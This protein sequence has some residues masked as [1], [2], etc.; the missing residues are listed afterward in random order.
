[1]L[2]K[3]VKSQLQSGRHKAIGEKSKKEKNL[4]STSS[5]ENI[6]LEKQGEIVNNHGG[7]D[8]VL[9]YDFFWHCHYIMYTL[10]IFNMQYIT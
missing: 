8:M 6:H 1:M 9:F 7:W 10:E 5:I 2:T 4:G 3:C